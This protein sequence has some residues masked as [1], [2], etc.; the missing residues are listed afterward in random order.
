[1][2]NT[3]REIK[4]RLV[5]KNNK[6]FGYER[7]GKN[8]WE[9]MVMELNPVDFERWSAGVL[10]LPCKRLSITGLKDKNGVDIY[11]GDIVKLLC[12]Y[13]ENEKICEVIFVNGGFT[14]EASGWFGGGEADITTVGWAI[15]SEIEIE[16]IGNKFE[17]PNLLTNAK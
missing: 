11:E 16:V 7:V 8:G 15:E 4:F 17:N 13:R 5:D 6:V 3:T 2:D 9:F 10:S 12:P 14:V 1:M